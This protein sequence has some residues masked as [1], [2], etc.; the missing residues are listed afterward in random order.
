M[1]LEEDDPKKPNNQPKVLDNLSVDELEEYIEDLKAEISRVEKE[2]KQKK[3]HNAA[4][5]ALF[6]K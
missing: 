6:G 3:G 2:I 1:L 4:A 5:E